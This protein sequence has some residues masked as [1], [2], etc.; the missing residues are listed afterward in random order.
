MPV[1]SFRSECLTACRVQGC[2]ERMHGMH[3][4]IHALAACTPL[5]PHREGH[6]G[7]GADREP[8]ALEARVRV[9][10]DQGVQHSVRGADGDAR[11][12][13]TRHCVNHQD[14]RP[15]ECK[16]DVHAV[17]AAPTPGYLVAVGHAV[18]PAARLR[19]LRGDCKACV[20]S[21]RTH[22]Q[23]SFTGKRG[24]SHENGV[25]R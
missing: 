1:A 20:H 6:D 19:P 9:R 11:H 12:G 17:D 16:P 5:T 24:R 4:T 25:W 3:G 22:T 10:D 23:S 7:I 18:A 13:A 21:A 8:Q 2:G 14:D 15:G